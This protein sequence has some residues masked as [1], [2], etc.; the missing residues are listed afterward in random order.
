MNLPMRQSIVAFLLVAAAAS[1]TSQEQTAAAQR[2]KSDE[3]ARVIFETEPSQLLQVADWQI[4][5][6]AGGYTRATTV[7]WTNRS[8]LA[9]ADL[10]GQFSYL[11]GD[12]RV[13]TTVPF[14]AEGD[15]GGGETKALKVYVDAVA[16]TPR[17]MHVHI[18]KVRIVAGR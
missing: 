3:R 5:R 8:N 10:E 15:I 16:G 9:V 18:E 13:M 6:E 17:G 4:E 11:D 2:I 14:T 12:G 1:C 7:S